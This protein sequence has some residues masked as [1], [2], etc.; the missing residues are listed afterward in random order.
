MWVLNMSPNLQ[1]ELNYRDQK[2]IKQQNIFIHVG[3]YLY[4]RQGCAICLFD[5]IYGMYI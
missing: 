4:E 5:A 2:R 3:V 1:N